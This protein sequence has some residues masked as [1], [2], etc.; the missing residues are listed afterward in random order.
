MENLVLALGADLDGK[1]HLTLMISDSLVKELGLD[2]RQLIREVSGEI[3]GGGGGQ[4]FYATAGGRNPKG[5]PQAL[6]I[7]SSRIEEAAG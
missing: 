3:Q 7:I 4:D 5:L 2:A 6:A 1:A